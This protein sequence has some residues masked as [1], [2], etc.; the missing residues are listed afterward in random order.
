[1]R[2]H[3]YVCVTD[4]A[5]SQ[6]ARLNRAQAALD[7]ITNKISGGDTSE[8]SLNAQ[9]YMHVFICV[10]TYLC[11]FVYMGICVYVCTNKI[12]SGD[13]SGISYIYIYIYVYI[14]I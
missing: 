8:V 12:V 5:S 11:V 4:E 14:Y 13:M 3:G 6:M 9:V 2:W 10:F 1:M 7:H